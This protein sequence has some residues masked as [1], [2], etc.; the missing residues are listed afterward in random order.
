MSLQ[1]SI[2]STTIRERGRHGAAE[3]RIC[4]KIFLSLQELK[5]EGVIVRGSR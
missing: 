1:N 5:T 3:E 4:E 2:N